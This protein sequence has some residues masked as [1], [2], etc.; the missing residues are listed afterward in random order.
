MN[1]PNFTKIAFPHIY[2][3]H[4]KSYHVAGH[5]KNICAAHAM[6]GLSCV[7][8]FCETEK[9]GLTSGNHVLFAHAHQS[10]VCMRKLGCG[11]L[12]N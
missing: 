2:R 1:G 6:G 4:S 3:P 10:V 12:V 7:L 11:V 9:F 8:L 5:A